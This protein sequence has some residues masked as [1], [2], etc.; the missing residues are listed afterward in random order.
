MCSA[1]QSKV[2]RLGIILRPSSFQHNYQEQWQVRRLL[3]HLSLR[4][5]HKLS[6]L[7]RIPMNPQFHMGLG[8]NIQSCHPAYMI[9]NCHPTHSMCWL[10]WPWFKQTKSTAPNHRSPLSRLQFW[11]PQWMRVPLKAGRQRTKNHGTTDDDTFY[12]VDEPRGAY[13]DIF[14]SNTFDSN[15]PRK[16]SIPSSPSSTPPR[17]RRQKRN[18]SMRISFA[19]NE[20]VSQ[21]TCEACRQPLVA[22]KTP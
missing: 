12:T 11:R 19:K 20:G 1:H 7:T 9:T 2:V 6:Q 14:S 8:V 13:W 5:S 15:E 16:L 17:S 3:S 21:H 18:L 4:W 22:K 10:L